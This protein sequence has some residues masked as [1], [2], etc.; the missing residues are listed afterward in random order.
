[1][2]I[3]LTIVSFVPLNR[4]GLFSGY[5]SRHQYPLTTLHT[6]TVCIFQITFDDPKPVT[7][8]GKK[9]KSSPPKSDSE[10]SRNSIGSAG[11]RGSEK[12]DRSIR[13]KSQI[14]LSW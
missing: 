8:R 7:P 10:R 13:Y 6:L 2:I 14:S 9:K 12:S 4:N 3:L 5:F 1:M 11:S